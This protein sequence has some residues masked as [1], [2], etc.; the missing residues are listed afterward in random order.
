VTIARSWC[1]PTGTG[2][3]VWKSLF[4]AI[5]P[6]LFSAGMASAQTEQRVALV[7]G[8]G[9]YLSVGRLRNPANDAAAVAA[10]LRHIGFT[11]IEQEDA[12]RRAMIQATRI[13]AEKLAPGGIGLL[14]YAGHGIQAQGANYL[15]PVDAS[16]AVEDDLK[17]ETLDLQDIL[18]K[19]DD[20]RVRLSIVILDACRNNPFKSFRS[21]SGGLAMI[22]PPAGTVIAYATAP[23]KVAEDGNG[24]HSV[25]TAEL[26]K[27]MA[28]P[29]KL[30]DVFEHVTDAVERQTGNAQTPWINSSFRGD[31]YFTGP[32]TVT[33]TPPPDPPMP[34]TSA[35]IVFWQSIASSTN[36]ADFEAYLKQF[37]QGSF[38][39]LAQIRLASLAIRPGPARPPQAPDQKP[40]VAKKSS[41]APAAAPKPIASDQPVNRKAPPPEPAPP[42]AIISPQPPHVQPVQPPATPPPAVTAAAPPP[43][44]NPVPPPAAPTRSSQS[45]FAPVVHDPTP[46][47]TQEAMVRPP[48]LTAVQPAQPDAVQ[49]PRTAPVPP[50]GSS[51]RARYCNISN[52]NGMDTGAGA[53]AT[54]RVVNS[55]DRCGRRIYYRRGEPFDSLSLSKPPIHGSVT[56]EGS[57]FYYTPS[58]GF[59]GEDE[60]VIVSTPWGHVRAVVTVVPPLTP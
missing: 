24:D 39:A 44:R 41:L 16:L 43:P 22:N 42:L 27:E 47:P 28:K 7:I 21:A 3:A 25:F 8:N 12:S 19:L 15:V 20:A 11:V 30:L 1:N 50:V 6:L 35:E 49:P 14:F 17:Y 40:P 45:P 51:R 46:L 55:G 13:F 32:T 52:F 9:S 37:P 38:A 56:I 58:P 34:T 53:Y 31:F 59:V 23:G 54:I 18:N 57:A 10:M 5:L 4:T 36:P 26:L 33:I 60:F 48:P 29:D 2:M